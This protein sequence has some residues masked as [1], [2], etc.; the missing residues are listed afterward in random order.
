MSPLQKLLKINGG[1]L[2]LPAAMT[3]TMF[4]KECAEM[5]SP[6]VGESVLMH[7][8]ERNAPYFF[9]IRENSEVTEYGYT[10]HIISDPKLF[11]N[12]HG[13]MM[14]SFTKM[15][16]INECGIRMHEERKKVGNKEQISFTYESVNP[17]ED[18]MRIEDFAALYGFKD[19]YFYVQV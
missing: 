18:S 14:M 6:Q 12:E 8:G 15:C 7:C 13:Q 9:T 1:K 17:I 3:R 10:P 16:G 19:P 4:C 5:E 11:E 2:I